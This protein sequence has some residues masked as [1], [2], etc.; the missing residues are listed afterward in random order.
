MP[1]TFENSKWK[2]IFQPFEVAKIDFNGEP[3]DS[4]FM[5]KFKLE[6]TDSKIELTF[7]KRE[8]FYLLK[9]QKIFKDDEPFFLN[10]LIEKKNV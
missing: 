2:S 3:N 8:S 5:S 7:L 1:K 10:S 6:S 4:C 9:N